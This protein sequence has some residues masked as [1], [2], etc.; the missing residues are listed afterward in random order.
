MNTQALIVHT[1]DHFNMNYG[2]TDQANA[3]LEMFEQYAK[4]ELGMNG[5]EA[6]DWAHSTYNT[7]EPTEDEYELL[8][9]N[10]WYY[11]NVV[12]SSLING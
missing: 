9:F 12:L 10:V 8:R 3:A 5:V 2:Q 7:T 11:I 4:D 1:T 6:M